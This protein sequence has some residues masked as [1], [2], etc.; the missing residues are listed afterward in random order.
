MPQ[1]AR[2]IFPVIAFIKGHPRCP[3]FGSGEK[4]PA[5]GLVEL[6]HLVRGLPGIGKEGHLD[7]VRGIFASGVRHFL[8]GRLLEQGGKLAAQTVERCPF[9]FGRG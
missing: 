4:L 1:E 2:Q 5:E 3:G 9:T 6:I 7:D 8:Q